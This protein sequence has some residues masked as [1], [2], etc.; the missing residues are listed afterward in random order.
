MIRNIRVR[1]NY[2]R[3]ARP[4]QDR[5]KEELSIIREILLVLQSK[6]SGLSV[7]R[8]LKKVHERKKLI[9]VGTERIRKVLA[10]ISQKGLNFI[11][12]LKNSFL[13]VSENFRKEI[14][15]NLGALS[16]SIHTKAYGTY[17]S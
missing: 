7:R 5:F 3:H 15:E 16:L 14:R 12:R 13:R 1:K 17:S 10:K 11:E 2:I 8:I 4:Q 9:G 6:P